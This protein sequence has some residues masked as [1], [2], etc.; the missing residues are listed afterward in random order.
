LSNFTRPYKIR[1]EDCDPA[2]IV[3]YPRYILMLH[4][5]F[6]D[7]FD[8]GLGHSLGTMTIDRKIGFPVV[9]LKVLF[10]RASRL[11]EILDWSL[12]VVRISGKSVNLTINATCNGE[13]RLVFEIT[14][15]SVNLAADGISSRE[16]PP[17]IREE[18][19]KFLIV[20]E[21]Y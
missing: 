13:N 7:W 18:M 1:F 20:K 4:R 10:Q 2:G 16:I 12:T 5:F 6:E 19:K 9:S 21:Q 11:E 8:E 15:V 17:D 14:L 3:F